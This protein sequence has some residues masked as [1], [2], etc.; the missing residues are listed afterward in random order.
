MVRWIENRVNR[1]TQRAVISDRVSSSWLCL[2]G[3]ILDPVLFNLLIIDLDVTHCFKQQ[4]C[5]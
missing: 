3:S 4:F 5:T 1:R 2:P